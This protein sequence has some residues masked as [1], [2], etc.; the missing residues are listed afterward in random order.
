[1]GTRVKATL[2]AG[3]VQ[4]N[5][6]NVLYT[7]IAV[8]NGVIHVIDKVLTV[9]GNI[10]EVASAAGFSTLLAAAT[11]NELAETLQSDNGGSGFTVFAPTN[12]AFDALGLSSYDGLTDVLLYHV[13]GSQV[14]ANAALGVALSGTPSVATS[15]GGALLDLSVVGGAL[16]LNGDVNVVTTDV[17]AR[18]GII[19]VIDTVLSPPG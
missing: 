9:P 13:L 8:S 5:D 6:A 7:D 15:S 18:N 4:V 2:A 19:H 1:M 14:D 11:A 17:I 16:R 3:G 12:A 10:V